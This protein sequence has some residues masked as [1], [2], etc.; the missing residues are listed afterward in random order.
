MNK[1]AKILRVDVVLTF[2]DELSVIFTKLTYNV[3]LL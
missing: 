1:M 3:Y 2:I